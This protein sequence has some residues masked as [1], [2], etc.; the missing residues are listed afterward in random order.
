[1]IGFLIFGFLDLIS[2]KLK[3]LEF[4]V[5]NSER[6]SSKQDMND[7][8]Q[9][10]PLSGSHK[11]SLVMQDASVDFSNQNQSITSNY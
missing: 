2:V 11:T 3:L 4:D 5:D 1:M 10:T 7:L 8:G 9:S 6:V